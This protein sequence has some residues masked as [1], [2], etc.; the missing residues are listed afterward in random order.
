MKLE[1]FSEILND[2]TAKYNKIKKEDYLSDGLFPIIDQGQKFIGG[3]TNDEALVTDIEKEFIIFGDHTKALK[4][5]NY[6]IAIGAD[7]VKVLH[8]NR[9]KADPK[10]VYYF[11]KSVKLIDAGYSRH[12]KFLK[13]IKI[14]ITENVN[15]Q[16]RIADI[17]TK[18]ETLVTQRKE[19]ILMLDE[20]LKSIFLE[21]FGDPI[22]NEKG[23]A[24]LTGEKYL[25]KLT[26]GVVIKPASHYVE[27]G[28][29]ALR[30]LNIRPNK[31]DLTNLV[32]FSKEASENELSKSIL[33]E[34][35][36]VFVRTGITGTAAI[37]PKELDG[38]NCIDLII[39][40]PKEE[41][42]NSKYLVFF[43]NSDIG[44]RIVTSNEVGGIQKHFN[45]GAL[46]SLKIPIPP[47]VLQNEFAAIVEKVESLKTEYQKSL[48][49]LENMYGVL[50]QKAFKGELDVSK[51]NI[52]NLRTDSKLSTKRF[53]DKVSTHFFSDTELEKR[54]DRILNKYKLDKYFSVKSIENEFDTRNIP[55]DRFFVINYLKK[56]LNENKIKQEYSPDTKQVMFKIKR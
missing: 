17:L 25:S 4:F 56:M 35:D 45:I 40:R 50:S 29:I 36:V 46:K 24:F 15:D 18:C 47:I 51:V 31:I 38:C 37:I 19:S 33:N 30:S 7:G 23:W 21:M 41:L 8:I 43:F 14:P 13:E 3:Y 26:V 10:Y 5:I 49:E 53:E 2:V 42:I 12:F 55:F 6:P 1:V 22:K 34:G 9:E 27:K 39:T 52:S 48:V 16:I 54:L 32:Y 44:K 28:V 11:L 20:L